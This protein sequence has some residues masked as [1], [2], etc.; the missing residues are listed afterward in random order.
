MEMQQ[1]N[2][3]EHWRHRPEVEDPTTPNI[4]LHWESR[5]GSG[6]GRRSRLVSYTFV[7]FGAALAAFLVLALIMLYS[8]GAA[9]SS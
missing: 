9:V 3:R 7:L 5:V 4:H 1:G 2:Y 8:M 6:V